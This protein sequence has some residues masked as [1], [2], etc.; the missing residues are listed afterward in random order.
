MLSVKAVLLLLAHTSASQPGDTSDPVEEFGRRE[1][2]RRLPDKRQ[3]EDA[4]FNTLH[5][6]FHSSN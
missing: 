6:R 3:I 5:D 2:R 1:Q 4:S